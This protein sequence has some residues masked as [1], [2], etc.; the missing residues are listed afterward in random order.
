MVE[1]TIVI[2]GEL[3]DLNKFIEAERRNRYVGARLKRE[4]TDYVMWQTKGLQPIK[5]YPLHVH[6]TWYTRNTRVDPDNTAFAKKYILDAL[7]ENGI[8]KDDS[9]KMISGFSD[10]FEVDQEKPRIEIRLTH[11]RR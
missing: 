1:Y 8:L 9:R 10:E 2:K 4:N 11:K 3:T 5:H 6:I 7:V